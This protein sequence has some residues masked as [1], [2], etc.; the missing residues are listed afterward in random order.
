MQELLSAASKVAQ[1][2]AADLDA[3][4]AAI[5]RLRLGRFDGHE[6]LF[7]SLLALTEPG[8]IQSVAITTLATFDSPGVSTL[9]IK[10]WRGLSPRVR[11]RAGDTL[12]SRESWLPP[13]LSALESG[14]ISVGDIEPT[15]LKLLSVHRNESLRQRALDLLATNRLGDRAK[16]VEEYRP[17]L[18]LAGDSGRGR[19]VFKKICAACHQAEGTGHAIGPNLAAMRNRGPDAILSNLLAPNQEVNPQYLNYALITTD[20]RAL[21]G[22][23]AAETATSVTLKRAENAS[24]TVLR[25]DI[26]ELTSTGVSLMPE[27]LEKQIDKSAMADLIAYVLSLQ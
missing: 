18:E 15:Q 6:D 2:K 26:E 4:V 5:Q 23:L 12:F 21:T 11:S 7:G 20:G 19:E 14:T 1:D 25:I 3:R 10:H 27:G 9:L 13:L 24:D 8:E 22:M 16:L 17:V